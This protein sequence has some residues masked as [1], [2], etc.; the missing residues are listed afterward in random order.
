MEALSS[1]LTTSI[2]ALIYTRSLIAPLS[3]LC[4]WTKS[5][6]G[7]LV[8]TPTPAHLGDTWD[9]NQLLAPHCQS[10]P[11]HYSPAVY[12]TKDGGSRKALETFSL[13][14]L[15]L[16]FQAPLASLYPLSSWGSGIICVFL[17]SYSDFDLRL[18]S[19]LLWGEVKWTSVKIL[20]LLPSHEV[21][22]S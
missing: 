5:V 21:T 13:S 7:L 14:L 18:L 2:N 19:A 6:A 3:D 16:S 4:F 8:S 17:H 22:L 9:Y 10:H 1:Q 15:C 11:V 12:C 20:T